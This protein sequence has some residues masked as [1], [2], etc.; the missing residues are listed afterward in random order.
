MSYFEGW[1]GTPG[2]IESLRRLAPRDAERSPLFVA[3]VSVTLTAAA[4]LML[5]GY[6]G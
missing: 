5:T 2:Q 4:V 3:L 6:L 1:S